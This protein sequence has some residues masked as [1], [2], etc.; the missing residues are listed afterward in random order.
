MSQHEP[1]RSGTHPLRAY[2]RHNVSEFKDNSAILDHQAVAEEHVGAAIDKLLVDPGQ[3]CVAD[4]RGRDGRHLNLEA[5]EASQRGV[6][7]P[8]RWISLPGIAS[9]YLP[10]RQACRH[11]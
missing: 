2:L 8:C 10:C 3:L 11:A 7:A 5:G 1:S 6:F 4:I 9:A